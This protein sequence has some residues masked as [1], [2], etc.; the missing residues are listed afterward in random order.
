MSFW[1]LKMLKNSKFAN[2]QIFKKMMENILWNLFF[3][4][5]PFNTAFYS[6]ISKETIR[7]PFRGLTLLK[8]PKLTIREC[9]CYGFALV[10][11]HNLQCKSLVDIFQSKSVL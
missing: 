7:V 2:F 5:F 1:G 10:R 3:F 11:S 4:S 6:G 9:L 8:S